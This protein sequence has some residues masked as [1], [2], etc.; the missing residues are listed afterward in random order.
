MIVRQMVAQDMPEVIGIERLSFGEVSGTIQAFLKQNNAVGKVVYDQ[1]VMGFIL[2]EL[3][4]IFTVV[5]FAVHPDHRRKGVG[6]KMLESLVKKF[7]PKRKRIELICQE[8]QLSTLNF[9]KKNGFRA[10]EILPEHYEN[11]D[12]GYLMIYQ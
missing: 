8:S 10:V 3:S 7:T 1:E 4:D 9:L 6:S 12:D 5:S 2:Y 11:S